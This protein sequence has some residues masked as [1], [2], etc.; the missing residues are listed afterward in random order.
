MIMEKNKGIKALKK[1]ENYL[2]ICGQNLRHKNKFLKI[3]CVIFLIF[4]VSCHA[5]D[6]KSLKGVKLISHRG[7]QMGYPENSLA[8]IE[9]V[10]QKGVHG[11]EVD[12]R[13]TADSHIILMHDERVDRTT[14]GSGKVR[15]LNWSEIEHLRLKESNGNPP[16][17]KVPDL[18]SVLALVK[19]QP[20]V[21][22]TLDLKDVDAVKVAK[23]IIAQGMEEQVTLFIADPM[24]TELSKT[25]TR[26]DPDLNIV[27]DMRTWWKI[28]DVPLF[29]AKA[30]EADMLF[31]SEWF[32]PQ[33]GFHYLKS[34]GI[35]VVVYLWGNHD[36]KRR[37]KNAVDL[38]AA[39]VSTDYPLLLLP[40]LS[41][42]GSFADN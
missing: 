34:K 19:K 13:T 40:L 32:F 25:I 31:A 16:F 33:R 1:L 21:M 11:V 22:L 8:A 7:M 26:L 9:A 3:L 36:L 35:D 17:H 4:P 14:T 42:P 23:V 28:E 41:T 12:L 30:L 38:G 6:G 20:Q 2:V 15:E 39:Y 5:Q 24:N 29:A 37:F 10:M 27:V 18:Q